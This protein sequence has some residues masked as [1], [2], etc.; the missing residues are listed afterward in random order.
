RVSAVGLVRVESDAHRRQA[1]TDGRNQVL[2]AFERGPVLGDVEQGAAPLG[3]PG[4]ERDFRAQRSEIGGAVAL[5]PEEDL[6]ALGA[7]QFFVISDS[8]ERNSQGET[9]AG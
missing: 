4:G 5:G 6:A 9:S 3:A 2:R 8:M 1:F 7:F